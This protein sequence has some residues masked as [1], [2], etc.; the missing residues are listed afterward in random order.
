MKNYFVFPFSLLI[1][2]TAC[3]SSST[4]PASTEFEGFYTSSFEVSSFVPCGMNE[5]SGYGSGYW[6]VPTAEFQEKFRF[7]LSGAA[8]TYGSKDNPRLFNTVY[9]RFNGS[10]SPKGNYGHLGAYTNEV[11]VIQVIEMKTVLTGT[12]RGK[13]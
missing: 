13:Q 10:L 7:T 11:N 6:L 12:C 9:V 3:V 8:G 5:Q 2:L 1:F 4:T